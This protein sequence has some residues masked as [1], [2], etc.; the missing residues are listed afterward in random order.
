LGCC[1]ADTLQQAEPDNWRKTF[2]PRIVALTC[3]AH[4]PLLAL[5]LAAE[6]VEQRLGFLQVGGVEA[7]SKPVADL[8]EHR[9]RLVAA[10]HTRK[11]SD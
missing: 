2:A 1:I 6:L 9:A 4:I 7:F 8:G 5:A 10:A 11:T 3:A